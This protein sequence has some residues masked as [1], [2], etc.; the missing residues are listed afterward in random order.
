MRTATQLIIKFGDLEEVLIVIG[1][2]PQRAKD[3]ITEYRSY[4]PNSRGFYGIDD[5]MDSIKEYLD[6]QGFE[7]IDLDKVIIENPKREIY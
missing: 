2:L 6:N 7:I 5:I 4:Y 1:L 3:K